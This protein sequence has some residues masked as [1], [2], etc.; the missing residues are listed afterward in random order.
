MLCINGEAVDAGGMK[1]AAYLEQAGYQS[2]RVVIE[3]NLKIV[4]KEAYAE[5]VLKDGD[6]LEILSF[7]GGG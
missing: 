6:N 2:N 5:L 7:V 3:L 4:P 1:L